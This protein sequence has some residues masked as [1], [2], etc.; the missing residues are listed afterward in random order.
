MCLHTTKGN[1]SQEY[2]F[3]SLLPDQANSNTNL[4]SLTRK[5]SE[6][7]NS[8]LIK[9]SVPTLP[10]SLKNPKFLLGFRDPQSPAEDPQVCFLLHLSRGSYQ[11]TQATVWTPL[12]SSAPELWHSRTLTLPVHAL[13]FSK[14]GL[15][16]LLLSG[17]VY[18][19]YLFV[20]FSI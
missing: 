13:P 2:S 7:L 8:L 14:A 17:N 11:L 4:C 12:D 5:L 6:G 20:I 3:F 15:V 9:S 19:L 1:S 18:H 16:H 10:V